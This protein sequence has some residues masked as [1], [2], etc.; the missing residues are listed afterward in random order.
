M[1][2]YKDY[3][4]MPNLKKNYNL[5][6]VKTRVVIKNA[7]RILKSRF[8]Q[9]RCLYFVEVDKISKFI[10]ACC[11][12]HNL[13]IIQKDGNDEEHY[14][15]L[16]T[17]TVIPETNNDEREDLLRRIGEIKRTRIAESLL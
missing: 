13:S 2:P 7:F 14:E 8:L 15:N 1:V 5:K 17:P 11:V 6:F 12:V 10:T 9:L 16:Q 3:G 4:N